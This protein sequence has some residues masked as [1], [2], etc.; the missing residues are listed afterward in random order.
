MTTFQTSTTTDTGDPTRHA[1]L[2]ELRVGFLR[3]ELVK[4]SIEFAGWALKSR[5]IGTDQCL[6]LIHDENLDA[7]LIVD[8]R[9]RDAT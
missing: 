4:N 2:L 8:R 5:L 1:L 6:D 7:F 3:A 9:D